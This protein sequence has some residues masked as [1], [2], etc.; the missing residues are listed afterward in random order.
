MILCNWAFHSFF[1][2]WI[3]FLRQKHKA[4]GIASMHMT[5]RD[6][7]DHVSNCCVV[8]VAHVTK[9]D[10]VT[11]AADWWRQPR[12]LVGALLPSDADQR[13]CAVMPSNDEVNFRGN[14]YSEERSRNVAPLSNRP[15]LFFVLTLQSFFFWKW[16]HFTCNFWQEMC[17]GRCTARCFLPRA[18]ELGGSEEGHTDFIELDWIDSI[19]SSKHLTW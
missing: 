17:S 8:G 11:T 4:L 2:W 19:W 10:R 16:S 5:K 18:V 9:G 7:C 12:R 1:F 3:F 6:L 14:A 13:G 15:F